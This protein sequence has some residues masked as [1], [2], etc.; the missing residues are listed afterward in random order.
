[1]Y[2][3][4]RHA[5]LRFIDEAGNDLGQGLLPLFDRSLALPDMSGLSLYSQISC[6]DIGPA[7]EH[8]VLEEG[9]STDSEKESYIVPVAPNMSSVSNA[10]SSSRISKPDTYPNMS[11]VSNASSTSRISKPDT[12]LGLDLSSGGVRRGMATFGL[13]VSDSGCLPI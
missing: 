1:M 8:P 7:L 11:N 9:K 3:L 13:R 10:S 12:Y 2:V 4:T 6:K 5:V